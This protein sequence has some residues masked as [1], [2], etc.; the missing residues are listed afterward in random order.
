MVQ[1]LKFA[2]SAVGSPSCSRQPIAVS[3]IAGHKQ[4]EDTMFIFGCL[5][6]EAPL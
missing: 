4:G 2:K 5:E 6:H 3:T 1:T